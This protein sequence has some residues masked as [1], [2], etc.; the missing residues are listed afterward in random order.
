MRG[1]VL[2]PM[3]RTMK[4]MNVLNCTQRGKRVNPVDDD[5]IY[6]VSSHHN[7]GD[8]R[9]QSVVVF[10]CH[11]ARSKICLNTT[12][13]WVDCEAGEVTLCKKRAGD[14]Q[15][16]DG[17]AIARAPGPGRLRTEEWLEIGRPILEG[18]HIILHTDTH[19]RSAQRMKKKVEG[20]WLEPKYVEVVQV[21]TGDDGY[22]KHLKRCLQYLMPC[23][24][25]TIRCRPV[26]PI[27]ALG[28]G[29]LSVGVAREPDERLMRSP[30]GI[31]YIHCRGACMKIESCR[32]DAAAG[33][34]SPVLDRCTFRREGG[35]IV[36]RLRN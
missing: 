34:Q 36:M 27:Q 31:C 2:D 29:H 12:L 11:R 10:C 17:T 8:K 13:E 14:G 16:R 18:R 30:G 25:A 24:D 35:F 5:K 26:F 3:L 1:R 20:R 23:S 7:A 32:C 4:L 6:V 21:E 15:V 33:E 19:A 28:D 22:W 9:I